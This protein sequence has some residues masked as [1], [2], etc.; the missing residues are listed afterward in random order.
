M[1]FKTGWTGSKTLT[2]GKLVFIT[3]VYRFC[4]QLL[5]D[6]TLCVLLPHNGSLGICAEAH[7]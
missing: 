7:P 4:N 3:F 2:S 6:S 5:S 1:P